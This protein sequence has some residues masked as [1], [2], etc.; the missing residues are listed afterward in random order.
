MFSEDVI[1]FYKC[2]KGGYGEVGIRLFFQ[3]T[4]IGQGIMALSCTKILGKISS[5]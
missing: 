3:L 1:T 2:L 4:K 5:L